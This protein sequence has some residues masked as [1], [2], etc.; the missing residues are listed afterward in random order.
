[1]ILTPD[2][3]VLVLGAMLITCGSYLV[4]WGLGLRRDEQ[5]QEEERSA[6]PLDAD[7]AP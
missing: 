7:L 6:A 5:Q 3:W 1:M 4:G 2:Q